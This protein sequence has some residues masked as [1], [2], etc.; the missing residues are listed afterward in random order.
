M[1]LWRESASPGFESADTNRGLIVCIGKGGRK[2]GASQSA[3]DRS[4][5]ARKGWE[6]RRRNGNA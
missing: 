2:G 4:A 6:T 1:A 5:A 3:A